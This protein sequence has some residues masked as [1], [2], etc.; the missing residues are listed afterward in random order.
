MLEE[1]AIQNQPGT[2][3]PPLSFSEREIARIGHI[4]KPSKEAVAA[5]KNS[6]KQVGTTQPPLVF[7]KS[8]SI[9]L[10]LANKILRKIA[11]TGGFV[12]YI[13]IGLSGV[14]NKNPWRTA[15]GIGSA[16][17]NVTS[18]LVKE[19]DQAL[20]H[21]SIPGQMVHSYLHPQ[22]N[23]LFF[24]RSASFITDALKLIAGLQ[25]GRD[26]EIKEGAFKIITKSI[27]IAGM[28]DQDRRER[29]ALHH[30]KEE[31]SLLSKIFANRW[32]SLGSS[33]IAAILQVQQGLE[34]DGKGKDKNMLISGILYFV[35]VSALALDNLIMESKIKKTRDDKGR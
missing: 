23:T 13:L 18:M 25:S 30:K 7:S 20:P 29:L 21:T 22:E 12:S 15:S 3:K 1:T 27:D 32:V 11:Y 14:A 24:N 4:D 31:R 33:T 19:N 2:I 5:E 34:G 8:E 9:P 35:N 17:L 28:S 6:D 10:G 26:K 16:A